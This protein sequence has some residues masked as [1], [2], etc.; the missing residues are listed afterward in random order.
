[1][2]TRRLVLTAALATG[3]LGACTT[4]ATVDPVATPD[5]D[6]ALAAQVLMAEAELLELLDSLVAGRPRRLEALAANR[7]VHEAHLQ[8]LREAA[9]A[10][11]VTS[12]ATPAPFTGDDRAA[13]LTLARAEDRL[14]QTLRRAAFSAQS[15]PFARV[16]AGMAAA[17]AQQSAA[18]RTLA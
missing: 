18:L 9:S 13:Y 14:G 10:A 2:P 6:T 5:P 4:D 12:T 16:L 15:G 11:P 7:A 3:A 8:L 1:M 17:T